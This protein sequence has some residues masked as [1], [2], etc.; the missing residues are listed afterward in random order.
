MQDVLGGGWGYR[1]G[2]ASEQALRYHAGTRRL[3]HIPMQA[4]QWPG[5][6]F[7]QLLFW[8]GVAQ[9]LPLHQRALVLVLHLEVD[10]YTVYI[11]KTYSDNKQYWQL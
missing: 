3:F 9:G 11:L 1:R 10:M 2:P 4:W 6:H 8:M 5:P 7:P